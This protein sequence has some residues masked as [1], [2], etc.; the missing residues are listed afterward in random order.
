MAGEA[1]EPSAARSHAASQSFDLVQTFP[2]VRLSLARSENLV[3]A[4]RC[5]RGGRTEKGREP[6]PRQVDTENCGSGVAERQHPLQADLALSSILH[7]PY[8]STGQGSVLVMTR[9]IDFFFSDPSAMPRIR[10]GKL[11]ASPCP[12]PHDP[13]T[14]PRCPRSPRPECLDTS[15]RTVRFR[16]PVLSQ[17]PC[18]FCRSTRCGGTPPF[19]R[20]AH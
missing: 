13:R 9:Q 19:R 16:R 11:R 20:A 5:R 2:N 1:F 6:R 10:A 14:C 18:L 15:T 7:V 8:P 3:G 4:G 12:R 17:E